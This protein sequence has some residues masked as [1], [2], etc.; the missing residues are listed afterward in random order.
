MSILNESGRKKSH[1]EK[2]KIDI[3]LKD[4]IVITQP[5]VD[6]W[7]VLNL[8]EST[9]FE[10][11]YSFRGY[12]YGLLMAFSLS[13]SLILIKMGKVLNGSEHA[14]IRYIVQLIFIIMIGK[15]KKLNFFTYNWC[16]VK[17]LLARGVIGATTIILG[18][19][20]VG[21]LEPSDV[22][23]LN[24]LTII[25]TAILARFILKE[26]LSLV[27]FIAALLSIT[28]VIFVLRPAFIFP[29]KTE[30]TTSQ[31]TVSINSTSTENNTNTDV[32]TNIAIG[33]VLIVLST[34]LAGA[35]NVI[36]KKLCYIKVW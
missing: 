11:I 30:L 5:E 18:L 1:S 10:R 33:V 2:S 36:I 21:L 27:H 4:Y 20:A 8:E 25:T 17:W 31:V 28:G 6:D 3:E 24:N 16:V 22:S 34:F 32:T 7:Q 19:F 13:M 35:T 23:T 9:I 15:F 12:F 26:K 29:R 14:A